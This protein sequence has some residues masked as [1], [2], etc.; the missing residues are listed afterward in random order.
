MN[1]SQILET[2]VGEGEG[3]KEML[4]DKRLDFGNM[5][6]PVNTVPDWLS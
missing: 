1:K 4:A 5:H 2:G 6:F 3:R